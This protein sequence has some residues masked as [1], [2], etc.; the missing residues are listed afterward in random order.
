MSTSDRVS[1]EHP[2]SV[3]D[4]ASLAGVNTNRVVYVI[5]TRSIT[6]LFRAGTVRV[7]GPDAVQRI[8]QE[9]QV[10]LVRPA[11]GRPCGQRE[12]AAERGG[13]EMPRK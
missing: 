13:R 3:G 11:V 6:P 9:L 10:T 5:R 1:S 12:A 7:F 8:L 2:L 4:I